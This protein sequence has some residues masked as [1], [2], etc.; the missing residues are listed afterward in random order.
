MGVKIVTGSQY[1]G[2]FVVDGAEE[3]WTN[4]KVKEC[5]ESV[6]TLAG[7]ARKHPQSAY[8]GLKKSLQ[9][10]WKS[11]QQVTPGIGDA[12]SLVEQLMWETFLLALFQGLGYGS[13]GRGV[14]ACQ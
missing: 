3:S 9:Q 5:E 8:S 4:E 2:D 14:S 11:M 7:V 10:K 13:S 6:K 1:L 12:F